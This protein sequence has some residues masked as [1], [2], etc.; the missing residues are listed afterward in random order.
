M[1]DVQ[2]G[3]RVYRPESTRLPCG[4]SEDE[5]LRGYAGGSSPS[6][7]IQ[8]MGTSPGNTCSSHE[9]HLPPSGQQ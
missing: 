2:D 3:A 8:P 5:L 9:R 6:D 7:G 4:L 1:S